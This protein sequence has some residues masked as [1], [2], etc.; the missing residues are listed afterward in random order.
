MAAEDMFESDAAEQRSLTPL[1]DDDGE[2]YALLWDWIEAGCPP[3]SGT[4][5]RSATRAG[6]T[7]PRRRPRS[8]PSRP[9]CRSGRGVDAFLE[10]CTERNV[11]YYERLGFRVVE[12]GEPAPDGPHVW[13]MRTG[14]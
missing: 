10:T 6:A 7:G 12:G 5:T 8:D 9:G 14:A 2:R 4:S 3:T 11:R 1:T 13:F